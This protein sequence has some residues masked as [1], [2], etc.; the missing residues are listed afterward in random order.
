MNNMEFDKLDYLN[1]LSELSKLLSSCNHSGANTEGISNNNINNNLYTEI[2]S[3]S[4]N[5]LNSVSNYNEDNYDDII[6][7]YFFDNTNMLSEKKKKRNDFINEIIN[8]K[9]QTNNLKRIVEDTDYNSLEIDYQLKLDSKKNIKFNR[10]T[11]KQNILNSYNSNLTYKDRLKQYD[12]NSNYQTCNQNGCLKNYCD[13]DSCRKY[14]IIVISKEIIYLR[15]NLLSF[16]NDIVKPFLLD[17]NYYDLINSS[18]DSNDNDS[19]DDYLKDDYL[20][21]MNNNN[22]DLIDESMEYLHNLNCSLIIMI[23]EQLFNHNS[24]DLDLNITFDEQILDKIR[25]YRL[26]LPTE[27]IP[28]CTHIKYLNINNKYRDSTDCNCQELCNCSY[29]KFIFFVNGLFMHNKYDHRNITS[30]FD[31]R[32]KINKDRLIFKKLELNEII[33]LVKNVKNLNEDIDA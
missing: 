25:G 15:D 33:N 17:N 14:H 13:I 28:K 5:D 21:L 24:L 31:L 6:K 29:Q 27:N 12:I 22:N 3:D 8:S 9:D 19:N 4:D 2:E 30:K 20:N 26:I 1:Q 16:R 11:E 23:I 32:W 10:K 18:D 7:D